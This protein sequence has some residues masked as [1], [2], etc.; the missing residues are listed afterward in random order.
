M[1]KA[2]YRLADDAIH[3]MPGREGLKLGAIPEFGAIP[4]LGI[5]IIG[6]ADWGPWG[7]RRLSREVESSI[8][9]L[10]RAFAT[11]ILHAIPPAFAVRFHNLVRCILHRNCECAN[12]LVVAVKQQDRDAESYDE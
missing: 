12:V 11:G 4:I 10:T 7:I 3:R 5:G 9:L 8:Y 2:I 6:G 1:K